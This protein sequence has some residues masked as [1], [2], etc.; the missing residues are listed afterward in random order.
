M[1]TRISSSKPPAWPDPGPATAGGPTGTGCIKAADGEDDHVSMQWLRWL[2]GRVQAGRGAHTRFR[3]Q[4]AR[5]RRR[6]MWRFELPVSLLLLVLLVVGP[7]T[8]PSWRWWT[9]TAFG[10][11][12]SM[13][14]WAWD[15]YPER[16][17]R[18]RVGAAGERR[19]ERAL[20]PLAAAG[21]RIRHDLDDHPY[22]NIDHVVIGPPGVF[23]LDSKVWSGQV[24][25][26][27]GVPVVTPPE[28]PAGAWSLPRL[29]IHLRA[30]ATGVKR[31]AEVPAWVQPVM[32]LWAP[33]PAGVV[34]ADGVVYVHGDRL[35]SW[36]QR[37]RGRLSPDRQA[38]LAAS[39]LAR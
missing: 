31:R 9:G 7:R 34:E 16:I 22:G 14:A 15:A 2:P 28:D 37:Q 6:V 24:T 23:V 4:R 3:H 29:P 21:W 33:F 32:V 25:I 10:A 20:R 13:W 26:E 11:L 36:L 27:D 19:T 39:V 17:E 30:M 8:P 38:Q 12:L 5:W 18:W 35:A 1:Q